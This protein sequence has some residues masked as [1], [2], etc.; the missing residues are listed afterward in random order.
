MFSTVL[1]TAN[2]ISDTF[3]VSADFDLSISGSYLS[4]IHLERSLDGI[5]FG[6]VSSY[7]LEDQAQVEES[8]IAIYRFRTD[9]L[10]IGIATV[11][12]A[13][14][15]PEVTSQV[16]GKLFNVSNGI[17]SP[18]RG[19]TI[20]DIM[21]P[22]LSIQ[23]K[24]GFLVSDIAIIDEY[25][26]ANNNSTTSTVEYVWY[27]GDLDIT[28]PAMM[29]WG[30]FGSKMRSRFYTDWFDAQIGHSLA[31]GSAVIRH[32][33]LIVGRN[34]GNEDSSVPMFGGPTPNMLTLCMRR[35]D[36]ATKVDLWVSVNIREIA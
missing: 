4:T 23:F 30:N 25:Q 36:S 1:T 17:L 18:H 21:V 29:P 19:F 28:G 31:P 2:Q 35:L 6:T 13:W 9:P 10:F 3:E 24:P 16:A 8:S 5:N 34:A 22:V 26:I 12:A 14:L 20:A 33:G 11:V 7:I 15:I 32:G 27:E